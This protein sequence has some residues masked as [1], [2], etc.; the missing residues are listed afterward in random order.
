M[1][2]LKGKQQMIPIE[3]NFVLV[4]VRLWKDLNLQKR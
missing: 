4:I 2:P 1:C 3:S